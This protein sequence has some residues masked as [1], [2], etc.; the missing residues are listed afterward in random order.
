MVM[1]K[2]SFIKRAAKT[3]KCLWSVIFCIVAL[4]SISAC[5]AGPS[6]LTADLGQQSSLVLGQKVSINGEPLEITFDSVI[7][8]SR[9]PTGAT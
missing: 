5:A 7:D 9:C 1:R 8:D 2:P 4:S 3:A 6:T